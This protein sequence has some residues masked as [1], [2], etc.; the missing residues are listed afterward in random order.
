[1]KKSVINSILGIGI[2]VF[3]GACEPKSEKLSGYE[4]SVNIEGLDSSLIYLRDFKW[5]VMDSAYSQEGKLT[6]LGEVSFPQ[7]SFIV[8]EGRDRER[9]PFFL[10]NSK[11]SISAHT[12]SLS[13]VV[14]SGSA[15]DDIIEEFDLA[16]SLLYDKLDKLYE[17]YKKAEETED[18]IA[19]AAM[20]Q[21][22]EDLEE[23][24]KNWE[25][26]FI[27]KNK[28]SAVAAHIIYRDLKYKVDVRELQAFTDTLSNELDSSKYLIL[29]NE[30]IEKL[31]RLE[32]GQPMI[33]FVQN[34]P[35][36]NSIDSKSF[37]GKY[38]LI[39]FWASWC[40]PCRQENP[41]VVIVYN[42]L[43]DLGPGFEILGVSFDTNREKWLAAIEDDELPWPHVSDLKGWK[44]EVGKMYGIEGI[45]HTILVDPDGKIVAHK[46]RGDDLREKLEEVLSVEG[47]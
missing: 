39:D 16:Q 6:F 9:I 27:V 13:G 44:N 36:G 24:F 31:L 21:Q 3:L 28:N 10:E 30:R 37:R 18:S 1:M 23:D 38:L 2:L 33:D 29:L 14:V 35:D 42:D 26:E 4:L 40:G 19:V 15:S 22:W 7:F 11:I 8:I 41:N 20:D 47:A 32:P 25:K 17:A 45:P 43:K 46:L 5:E 34:D 12:D